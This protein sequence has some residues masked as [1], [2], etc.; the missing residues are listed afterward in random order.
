MDGSPFVLCIYY[1]VMGC[2]T[3]CELWQVASVS[4]D[5][6]ARTCRVGVLLVVAYAGVPVSCWFVECRQILGGDTSPPPIW[7][8]VK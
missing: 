6:T 5:R 8:A 2:V 7:Q 3:T 1:G 4:N